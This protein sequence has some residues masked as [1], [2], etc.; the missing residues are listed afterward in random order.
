[1]A[2]IVENILGD[3]ALQ[4]G[5]EEFVRKLAIGNNW[6]K[7]HIA[8]RFI[9]NGTANI[10]APTRCMVGLCS[11][12]EFTL[13]SSSCIGWVGIQ[14]GNTGQWTY[15]GANGRY[16]I[17]SGTSVTFVSSK[18]G[19]VITDLSTG[20]N[21]G[22]YCK[23]GLSGTP[24]MLM[25]EIIRASASSYTCRGYLPDATQ[26]LTLPNFY[27]MLRIVEDEPANGYTTPYLDIL[28][29]QTAT[30]LTSNLDTLSIF[31]GKSTPTM[32]ISDVCVLR[33]Y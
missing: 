6:N 12:D 11:G 30:G 4:L 7:V 15:D 21:V 27:D 31:W 17:A 18:I 23:T 28:Q 32:E 33:Y 8:M 14:F 24:H 13:Q 16:N 26:L 1:M 22:H 20:D 2:S 10:A 29:Q 25:V 9:V 5:G 19:A 3:K